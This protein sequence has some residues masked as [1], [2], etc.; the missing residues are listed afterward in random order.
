MAKWDRAQ[1]RAAAKKYQKSI[2]NSSRTSKIESRESKAPLLS[3]ETK[4]AENRIPNSLLAVT[5][6]NKIQWYLLNSKHPRGK[7][8]AKVFISVLGYHYENWGTF[9]DQIF[10]KLQTSEISKYEVTQY[11]T[12]YKVPMRIDGL[13]G[14][15]M[16]I[17]TVWQVD[18]GTDVPRL[19]TITFDKRTIRGEQ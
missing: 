9:S 19:I 8:K 6:H 4:P 18:N 7:E 2:E 5:D 14:K 12:R 13:K 3:E 15:N 11:G 1:A 10:D 16:V 17:N